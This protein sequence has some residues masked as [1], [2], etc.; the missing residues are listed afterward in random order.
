M[1]TNTIDGFISIAAADNRWM[2]DAACVGLWGYFDPAEKGE[3]TRTPRIVAAAAT[4]HTCPVLNACHR[5]AQTP[6]VWGTDGLGVRAGLLYT[7]QKKPTVVPVLDNNAEHGTLAGVAHH[8]HREQAYCPPCRTV[9][10][11]I[12]PVTTLPAPPEP[13]AHGTSVRAMQH[14]REGTDLC[15]PCQVAEDA[16]LASARPNNLKKYHARQ[17]RLRGKAA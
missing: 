16:R 9:F 13:A 7:S 8:R 1:T 11:N 3:T 5:S 6:T 17:E 15:G 14:R 12:R 10:D 4:C 2:A